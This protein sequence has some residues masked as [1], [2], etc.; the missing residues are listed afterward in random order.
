MD[1]KWVIYALA[2]G[3]WNILFTALIVSTI[4]ICHALTGHECLGGADIIAAFIIG[5]VV[6]FI[7][8]VKILDD[9]EL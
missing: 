2:I 8:N 4:N 1:F 7:L 9:E 6:L 3:I 5:Y